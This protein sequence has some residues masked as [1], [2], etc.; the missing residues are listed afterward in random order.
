MPPQKR[1]IVLHPLFHL[2]WTAHL[3]LNVRVLHL[4]FA[5]LSKDFCHHFVFA[6]G[7]S[8]SKECLDLFPM[9]AHLIPTR[10]AL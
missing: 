2:V 4:T 6:P 10:L 7:Q 9:F 5:P 3:Q 8:F 1:L